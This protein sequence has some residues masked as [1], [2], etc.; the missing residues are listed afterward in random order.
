MDLKKNIAVYSVITALA[1][2][3]IIGWSIAFHRGDQASAENKTSGDSN[4]NREQ[5]DALYED[6]FH[7]PADVE[8]VKFHLGKDLGQV[9]R[10]F[11][12]SKEQRY[13]GALFKA[14]KAYE[15]A[16]R[17]PGT[18]TV[19]E[20]KS[21]KALIDSALSNLLAWADTLPDQNPCKASVDPEEA[22]SAIEEA[23]NLLDSNGRNKS[24][25]GFN[26]E[27]EV[28]GSPMEIEIHSKCVTPSLSPLATV[29][30][31]P[32]P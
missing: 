6:V 1:V 26:D 29:S 30:P 5:L 25:H 13:Y 9:L 10:D 27:N 23:H 22:R 18:L 11:K 17:A 16:R 4:V 28:I 24:E 12:N 7:R 31:T 3:A 21:Y 32:T 2:V 20:V 8:G 15:E 14:V 19:D